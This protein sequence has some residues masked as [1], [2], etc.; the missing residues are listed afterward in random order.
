MSEDQQNPEENSA[1]PVKPIVPQDSVVSPPPFETTPPPFQQYGGMP[2]QSLPNATIALVLGILS[3]PG[4]CCYGI[5]GLILGIIAWVLAKSDINK[6]YLHPGVYSDSSFKNAKAGKVCGI[7]GA[8]LGALYLIVMIIIIATMG[9]AALKDP[10][11]MRE[12][13][14][15]MK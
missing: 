10:A 4:C 12:W 1:E 9:F 8:I 13:A 2:Q 3:I 6:F 7:I 5:L 15:G 14:E 11:V